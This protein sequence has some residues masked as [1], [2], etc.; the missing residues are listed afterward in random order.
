M[1]HTIETLK[2]LHEQRFAAVDK[3]IVLAAEEIARRLEVLNHYHELAREKERS[4]I[5]RETF[6]TFRQRVADDL[7]MLRR[8]SETAIVTNTGV[9]E[10]AMKSLSD[11]ITEQNTN[12]EM[13]FGKIEAVHAK[14]LGG[15]VLGT[16]IL[17]LITGLVIYVVTKSP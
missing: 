8:D 11:G 6:E 10:T 12:N 1:T 5:N 4:F 13:R 16:F 3:G 14:I 2:E 9:R 7:A 15:L 17:P